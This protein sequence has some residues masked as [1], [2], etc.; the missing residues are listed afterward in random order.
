MLN[1]HRNMRFIIIDHAF[2]RKTVYKHSITN[3]NALVHV[4]LSKYVHII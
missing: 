4:H 3:Y 2:T 1:S